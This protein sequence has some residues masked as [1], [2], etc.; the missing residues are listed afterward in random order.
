[1]L[2]PRTF[3]DVGRLLI[4]EP[5]AELSEVTILL[6]LRSGE[7]A[8][9]TMLV[10][11]GEFVEVDTG[12]LPRSEPGTELIWETVMLPMSELLPE[13]DGETGT[14]LDIG[15][16]VRLDV[17]ELTPPTLVTN[18]L[19]SPDEDPEPTPELVSDP[20]NE[21]LTLVFVTKEATGVVET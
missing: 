2:K 12:E 6:L 1:M 13:L 16:L 4:P 18:M 15:K 14:L 9:P 19:L 11:L 10:E 21:L 3:V 20:S 5:D 7:D 8:K 17:K